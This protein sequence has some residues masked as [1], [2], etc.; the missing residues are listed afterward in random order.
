MRLRASL[1]FKAQPAYTHVHA[2]DRYKSVCVHTGARD[3]SISF[4]L[5]AEIID[6]IVSQ[7]SISMLYSFNVTSLQSAITFNQ[8]VRIRPIITARRLCPV[9]CRVVIATKAAAP[10]R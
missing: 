8:D 2:N 9:S 1:R 6:D 4:Y 7:M 5:P 3:Q 10:A